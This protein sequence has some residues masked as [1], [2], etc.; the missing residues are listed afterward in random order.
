MKVLFLDVDGVL[1]I[2]SETYYSH[3]YLTLGSDPIEP[4]LM[5][6]LE[7]IMER[8]P[9]TNIVI[10]STWYEKQLLQKLTKARFKYLDRII[11]RTPRDTQ[12][13][14]DQI[15]AWLSDK[16]IESYIVLEDEI[17]DVCG[18]KCSAIPIKNVIEVNSNEGLSHKNTIDSVV[19]LNSLKGYGGTVDKLNIESYKFYYNKG[20][21]AQ[22]SIPMKDDAVDYDK[23]LNNWNTITIDNKNLLMI[24]SKKIK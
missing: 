22:V 5:M 13:R 20:Y 11:G 15:K 4:H 10:S 12:F 9:D 24:L 1:N 14:G 7:Y 23:L 19:E 3:S 18:D 2:M 17:S 21:R 8:C 6:R 16:D